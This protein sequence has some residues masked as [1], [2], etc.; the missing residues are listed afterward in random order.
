MDGKPAWTTT[1]IIR[2][3]IE[4]WPNDNA[5]L[6]PIDMSDKAQARRRIVY[7]VEREMR[8]LERDAKKAAERP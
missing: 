3:A 4:F 2:R 8:R 1:M 6:G 7:D 5:F